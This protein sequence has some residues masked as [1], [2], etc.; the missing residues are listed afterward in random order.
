MEIVVDRSELLSETDYPFDTLFHAVYKLL[1][2]CKFFR[3]YPPTA[4]CCAANCLFGSCSAKFLWFR[5][6]GQRGSTGP[7]CCRGCRWFGVAR[8]FGWMVIVGL[9]VPLPYYARLAV[10]YVSP[11][12]DE[13]IDRRNAT[14]LIDLYYFWP[15][16]PVRW[17]GPTHPVALVL[18]AVYAA[19]ATLVLLLRVCCPRQLNDSLTGCIDDLC[20]TRLSAVVRM[21]VAHLFL[22][23][24][25]FG[26]VFGLAV[27]ALYWP[28]ALLVCLIVSMCYVV[29]TFYIIGRLL[30]GSRPS[31][32]RLLPIGHS[33][34]RHSSTFQVVG[35]D[36]LTDGVTSFDTCCFLDS[37]SPSGRDLM[38]S[39][40]S[41]VSKSAT[42]ST[43]K[44]KPTKRQR[45]ARRRQSLTDYVSSLIVGLVLVVFFLSVL[46]MYAEVFGF[47]IQIFS[48][49]AVGAVF[50]AAVA[51]GLGSTPYSGSCGAV[52]YVVTG[53]WLAIYFVAIYR[54]VVV[55]RYLKFSRAVFRGLRHL[56][57][58]QQTIRRDA[59]RNIAFKFI[60]GEGG[61]DQRQDPDIGLSSVGTSGTGGGCASFADDTIDYHEGRLHWNIHSLGL[62]FDANDSALRIPRVLFRQLCQLDLP[63]CPGRNRTMLPAVGWCI[64][65]TGYMSLLGLAIRLAAGI[66][67]TSSPASQAIATLLFGA[68][69]LVI[70]LIVTCFRSAAPCDISFTGKIRRIIMGYTRAWPVHDLTF[71]REPPTFGDSMMSNCQQFANDSLRQMP[72]ARK[73]ADMRMSSAPDGNRCATAGATVAVDLTQVDLLITIRDDSNDETPAAAA[74]AVV[75]AGIEN[76]RATSDR[77]SSTSAASVFDMS[78]PPTAANTADE[79]PQPVTENSLPPTGNQPINTSRLRPTSYSVVTATDSRMVADVFSSGVVATAQYKTTAERS[80]FGLRK[81]TPVSTLPVTDQAVVGME[82][83]A[84]EES[85]ASSVLVVDLLMGGMRGD[86]T[87]GFVKYP[88]AGLNQIP[89]SSHGPKNAVST[90]SLPSYKA[91][92][93][94]NGQQDSSL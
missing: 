18:Y 1:I 63:G 83:T 23:I 92:C 21:V 84:T 16:D 12:A 4:G 46:L 69:P 38:T 13:T 70:F 40:T 62:F 24:E 26:L 90:R 68:V 37:I 41:E 80:G 9:L 44:G 50:S 61:D 22:P 94:E 17:L 86:V 2:G 3:R 28:L 53:I 88:T 14:G 55:G 67:M 93:S 75:A 87:A 72:S 59:D 32:F 20:H 39:T 64:G 81:Q 85:G 71:V 57:V 10:Y 60:V 56:A 5:L 91:A 79:Q 34:H 77:D 19:S 29:P 48:I 30:I 66:T 27:G 52:L 45:A 78:S 82:R 73:T 25:K 7:D 42:S 11:D 89:P 47:I 31:C 33:G 6:F 76:L 8:I 43:D 36:S 74:T 49:T 58:E 65:V 51:T 15:H 35:E 54:I